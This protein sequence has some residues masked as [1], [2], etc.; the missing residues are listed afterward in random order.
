MGERDFVFFLVQFLDLARSLPGYS[1]IV[2][3]HCECDAR[4]VGHVKVSLT[5][6]QLVLQ[7][8]STDGEDEVCIYT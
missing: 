7:A 2:F 4:K 5:L 1:T 3:P 8:C 6:Q